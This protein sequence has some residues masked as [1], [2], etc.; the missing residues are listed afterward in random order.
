MSGGCASFPPMTGGSTWFG[1][2]VARLPD[3]GV[4]LVATDLQGNYG[5]YDALK[6]IYRA[7]DEAGNLSARSR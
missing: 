4:L 1:R 5:D 2:K 6:A 7:E 3:H